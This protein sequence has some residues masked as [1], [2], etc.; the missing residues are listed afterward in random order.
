IAG[1]VT[2]Y[3]YDAGNRLKTRTVPGEGDYIYNWD[4]NDNFT[5]IE[6]Y[7]TIQYDSADKTVSTYGHA[8]TYTGRDQTQRVSKAGGY[9]YLYDASDL[10]PAVE[11]ITGQPDKRFITS[12][13]GELLALEKNGALYYYLFDGSGSVVGVFGYKDGQWQQVNSYSYEP[14]GQTSRTEYVSQPYRFHGGYHDSG[15]TDFYKMGARY[16]DYVT[17]RFTQPEPAWSNPMFNTMGGRNLLVSRS[18][19]TGAGVGQGT[20]PMPTG[21]SG[22][23]SWYPYSENNPVNAS[24]ASG[25]WYL[26]INLTVGFVIGAMGGVMLAGSG[27]AYPYLGG[28]LTTPGINLAITFSLSDPTPGWNVAGQ[29]GIWFGMQIGR[30][31]DKGSLWYGEGGFVMP[32]ASLMAFKVFGPFR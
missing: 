9:S 32:G 6:G 3:D 13:T 21:P 23:F 10:G 5:G 28:G 1:L 22:H 14:F 4:N 17:G 26:D 31:L 30:G 7:P 29:G 24:D 20:T 11:R 2:S 25:W 27:D 19:G 18:Y 8:R 16:Y 12:P 15:D